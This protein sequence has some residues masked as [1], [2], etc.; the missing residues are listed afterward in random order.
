MSQPTGTGNKG[1]PPELERV[2]ARGVRAQ[3][4]RTHQ[5]ESQWRCLLKINEFK[6]QLAPINDSKADL[7]AAFEIPA[8]EA[9]A[10][11]KSDLFIIK[12]IFKLI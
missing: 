5:N 4:N 9:I 3:D 8:S 1:N 2:R 6:H 10:S 11:I 12:R 7:A